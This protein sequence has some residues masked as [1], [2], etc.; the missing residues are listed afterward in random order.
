[1][2]VHFRTAGTGIDFGAKAD[3]LAVGGF[4]AFVGNIDY[5]LLSLPIDSDVVLAV[6][7]R[8]FAAVFLGIADERMAPADFFAVGI[9]RFPPFARIALGGS[10]GRIDL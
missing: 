8:Q 4:H 3:Q 5:R 9:D 10:C 7:F 6:D 1:M 2:T